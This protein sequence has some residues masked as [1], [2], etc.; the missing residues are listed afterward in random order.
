MPLSTIL[1][2]S[3]FSGLY[4]GIFAMY[5]QCHASKKGNNNAKQ[6]VVFYALCMLYVLSVA[7]NALDIA[8]YV[9]IQFVSNNQ[10][11]S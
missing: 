2:P 8:T 3:R 6:Q 4:S 11:L 9:T 1:D 7:L 5:V 10:Y